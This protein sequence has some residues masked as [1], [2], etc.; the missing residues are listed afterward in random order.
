ML[1]LCTSSS[2]LDVLHEPACGNA[3][4]SSGRW[5]RDESRWRTVTPSEA[6]ALVV[7]HKAR[8]ALCCDPMAVQLARRP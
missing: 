4:D 1:E 7:H 3:D 8:Y 5:Q 2:G 6:E